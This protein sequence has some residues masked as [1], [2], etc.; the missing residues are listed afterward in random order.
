MYKL[1]VR[2]LTLVLAVTNAAYS[3]EFH[4]FGGLNAEPLFT[5]PYDVSG[6]GRV[7]VGLSQYSTE[8]SNVQAFRWTF[9]EGMAGL[10]FVSTN[11]YESIAHAVSYDGS[12]IIGSSHGMPLNGQ[13]LWNANDG[14][15]A[16]S[17]NQDP[18]PRL[19]AA[20]GISADGT[21]V[22][23]KGC[24]ETSESAMWSREGGFVSLGD[25]P[26]GDTFGF[27]TGISANGSTVV[28]FGSDEDGT[29]AYRWTKADG[30][31][32]IGDLS[33]GEFRSMATGISADGFTVVGG[34]SSVFS[35][36]EASEAFRWTQD[37]GMVGLDD[38]PGGIFAS[39]AT[40][41]S[42]DG[43][44]IVGIAHSERGSEA[45]VWDEQHGMR[46]LYDLLLADPTIAPQLEG[47]AFHAAVAVSDDGR[48]I[49]GDGTNPNGEREGWLVRIDS[50]PVPEP[51]T[52]AMLMTAVICVLARRRVSHAVA[53]K[54][55]GATGSASERR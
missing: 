23:G 42:A 37:S 46:S 3:A 15:R 31:V 33:G 39:S 40:D 35:G 45:F 48:T 43:S 47:W 21:I 13:F 24:S 25:L 19:C 53:A 41:V 29:H 22:V 7:V 12:S 27:A 52:V 49:V 55:W 16:I 4:H 11:G 18:F 6:D 17:T 26:G 14:M 5:F 44:V 2:F 51:S 1:L 28:G 20:Y 8:S 36:A 54:R 32:A 30:I 34:S 50:A 38:L 9:E 10:G